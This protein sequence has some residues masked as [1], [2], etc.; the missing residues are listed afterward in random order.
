MESRATEL[1]QSLLTKSWL[2]SRQHEISL[3]HPICYVSVMSGLSRLSMH[4]II[5]NVL[6]LSPYKIQTPQPLSVYTGDRREWF[7]NDLFQKI[8]ASEI[9]VGSIWLSDEAS[10]YLNDFV[11]KKKIGKFEVLKTLP[12]FCA[13]TTVSVKKSP[14]ATPF[15]TMDTLV[16]FSYGKP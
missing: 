6:P 8:D 1:W 3:D 15:S 2:S 16:N 14:Y 11:N 5:L 4:I 12:C 7:V 9:D 10:F 13:I